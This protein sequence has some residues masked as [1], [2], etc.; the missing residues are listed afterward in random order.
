MNHRFADCQNS[1][2]ADE[3]DCPCMGTR[4]D[5]IREIHGLEDEVQRLLNLCEL[6]SAL[7]AHPTEKRD[8]GH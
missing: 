5:L 7:P 8:D 2:P 1:D 3:G 6:K 4:T